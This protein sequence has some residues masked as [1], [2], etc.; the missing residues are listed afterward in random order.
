MNAVG[1]HSLACLSKTGFHK[2]AYR[3]SG[4][5]HPVPVVCLHGLGRN[6]RDFDALAAVLAAAGRRVV[7]A[8]VVGRGESDWLRDPVDY[9]YPQYLADTAALIARL[10]SRQVDIVGTS[11]GGLIGMMLAAQP[12][13]PLRRLVINDVGPFIPKAA[14]ERILDYF[15]KDPRFADLEEAEAYHRRV[16]AGFGD[17]TDP[18]W[19]HITETSVRR[20]GNAW[21]LHYDPRI[22]EPMRQAEIADVDLW[23]LWDGIACPTLV[24][25]GADSDLLLP[26]TAAEMKRRGPRAEVIE[27]PG[28]GHAPALMEPAQTAPVCDWLARE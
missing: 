10:G 15:G 21:R 9:G 17:L 11:M 6:A 25:R 8:D 13:T 23:A 12:D 26:E 19:R 16:Y 20:D 28:C 18:Q 4:P 2:L 5:D 22:A 27:F 14:L 7:C 1:N 3:E 24:L